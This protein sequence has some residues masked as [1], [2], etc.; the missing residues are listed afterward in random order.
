M[1]IA[2]RDLPLHFRPSFSMIPLVLDSVFWTEADDGPEALT[3][4]ELPSGRSAGLRKR[5]SFAR[6]LKRA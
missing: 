3:G 6:S 2:V 4:V 1:D 5:I